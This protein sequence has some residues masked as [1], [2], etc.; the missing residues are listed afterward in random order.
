MHEKTPLL[1]SL[2]EAVFTKGLNY[3]VQLMSTPQHCGDLIFPSQDR[4][5]ETCTSL[6]S[7]NPKMSFSKGRSHFAQEALTAIPQDLHS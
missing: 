5:I 6:P 7:G 2:E 4:Q 1:K 3:N